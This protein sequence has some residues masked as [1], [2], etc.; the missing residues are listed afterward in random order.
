ML[1]TSVVALG[2][3]AMSAIA[4]AQDPTAPQTCAV[5]DSI[6][7]RGNVR[8]DEATIRAEAGLIAGTQLN[9]RIVARA[10]RGLYQSGQYN[11]VT[12]SCEIANDRIALVISVSERPLLTDATVV[13]ANKI[14]ERAVR[15]QLQLQFGRALDPAAVAQGIHRVDSLYEKNGYYLARIVAETTLV[16]HSASLTFRIDEGNRLAVSGI[17]VRGNNAL[18]DGAIAGAMQ[19]KP[20]GFWWW[21]KGEFDDDKYAGDLAERIPGL[22]ARRGFI[23]FR[24]TNDSVI[25]DRDRG[26][27]LIELEVAEGPR[28]R[29][30]SFEVNG[31]R[32]FS[33]EEI[34]QFY[35]FDKETRTLTSRVTDFLRRRSRTPEGVFDQ[36]EW[37]SATDRLRTAYSNEGYI[38]AAVRPVVERRRTEDS[39]PV[40]DLRWDIEERNP[41]IINRIEILGNDY[42]TESCIRDALS[43]IPGQ[44]FNQDALIRSYQ[45]ISNLGFFEA[46]LPFPDTRTSNEAGDID[47]VF[48]VKE[49][50]TGNV[51][52]GASMGQ[53]YGVGG[54]IGFDQPNLFGR[55]KRGSLQWQFGRYINNF[56]LQYFDPR[57]RESLISGSISA[58]HQLTRFIIGDLG[59]F[60]QT[61]ATLGVGFPVPGSPWTRVQLTYGAEGVRLGRGGLT[62]EQRDEFG[63]GFSFRSNVG[64]SVTHDT[65]VDLPFASAGGMQSFTAQFNGGPLGG[66]YGFQRYTM[67]SRAYAPLAFFG[68]GRPGQQPMKLLAGLSIRAG[69]VAGNT[70]PFFAFQEFAVGGVQYTE[71]LRGYDEFS[72]TPRGYV[73]GTN[74]FSARRESF[75]KAFLTTTAEIGFRFNQSLYLNAFYDAG[76][77]W[78]RA[79][80]IDPTRLFRG[81]GIG[82]STVTPLGPLGIDVAYGFDRVDAQG[83]PQPGWK[84]H[85]R[86]GQLF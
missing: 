84:T 11:Q 63:D 47:I 80:E 66:A 54:F 3:G 64:F 37:Q 82:V 69:A 6:A 35:P 60:Q 76:N 16:E 78:Q 57:V 15:D 42:T 41:A 70:G 43:L 12:V 32:R 21:R 68:G 86:L 65:R 26:K 40:V 61:G 55:C 13:G 30:G 31:N 75:G 38:Y 19:I 62:G 83:R 28:Y 44:V 14:S 20:E 72:I 27:A 45:S 2:L 53:G 36:G 50:R 5:A 34:S 18:G 39:V 8:V 46:P 1:R 56:N 7:V 74:T 49:K 25:I 29:V 10:V 77:V 79:R 51:N 23:D 81:S 4:A 85:F 17:Q 59:R 24:V 67:E 71:M 58:Y 52:F 22:Y 9:S 33:S 73:S 48:R